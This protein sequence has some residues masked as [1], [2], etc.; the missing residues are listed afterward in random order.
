MTLEIETEGYVETPHLKLHYHELGEGEPLI[1]IHGG[2]PGATGW[3][4]YSKN[5]EALA[6]NFRTIVIDLPGYGKSEKKSA[7]GSLFEFLSDAV[8]ALMDGLGIDKASFVGNSLGGGTSLKFCVRFPDRVNRLVLMGPAGSLPMFTP[9]SEGGRHMFA[10]YN[11]TGPSVQK[12]KNFIEYMVYDM[13]QITDELLQQRYEASIDPAVIANP[14]LSQMLKRHPADDLWRDRL[15]DLSHRT[16]LI[17]G[18]EDRTVTLDSSFV[19]LRTL[20]NAQLHVF[21]NCGH[22]AQWER[23]D[24]FNSLV[25][26]FLLRP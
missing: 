13:S 4:N 10:Y 11:G 25:T 8:L 6:K 26:D 7:S 1:L 3:S 18:R 22:W 12:L 14:P 20:P 17:W 24:E 19:L 16:L 9:V 5:F 2:G 21:P 15:S 23:P